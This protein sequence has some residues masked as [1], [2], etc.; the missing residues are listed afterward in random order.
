MLCYAALSVMLLLC[1]I[2]LR[3]VVLC[4]VTLSC[5]MLCYVVMLYLHY[6]IRQK[7][8]TNKRV[9]NNWASYC[10]RLDSVKV[11]FLEH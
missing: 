10:S 3:Y 2:V 5:V 8:G 11:A 7:D 1:C 6:F 4:Y 9:L